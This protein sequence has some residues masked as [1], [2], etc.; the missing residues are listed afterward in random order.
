MIN[1]AVGGGTRLGVFTINSGVSNTTGAITASS[2]SQVAGSTTF[3]ALSTSGALGINLTGSSYTLIGNVITTGTGPLTIQNTGAL[4]LSG[5]VFSISGAVTQAGAGT[6]LSSAITAGAAIQFGG[7]VATS[8]SPSLNTSVASESIQLLSTLNGPGAL[9]L[10]SGGA[11]TTLQTVGQTTRLGTLTFTNA[12]NISTGSI[13]A[14]SI[15]STATGTT[16]LTGTLNT[17]AISGIEL[18]GNIFN[19]NDTI[20]TTNGGPCSIAHTGLLT[21]NAGASTLL[22]GSFTETGSANILLSGTIH[23]VNSNISF[24]NPITL[25]NPT[26]LNSDG[27]GD[28]LISNTVDGNTDLD[29][30]AG[31]GNI[32]ITANV[33][34]SVPINSMTINSANNVTTQSVSAGFI[35]QLAGGGLTLFNGSVTTT[36]PQ[37]IVLTGN[38]FTFEAPVTTQMSGPVQI[39]NA[40]LLSITSGAPMTLTGAFSQIGSGAVSLCANISSSGGNSILFTS[41]VTLCNTVVLDSDVGAGDVIFLSSVDGN[42]NLTIQAGSGNIAFSGG[43]GQ[44]TPLTA[45]DVT[46]G[47]NFTSPAISAASIDFSGLTGLA[48]FNGLLSTTGVLGIN[49]SGNAFTFNGNITTISNGP[50]TITSSGPLTF[51]PSG[52]LTISGPLSFN[53]TGSISAGGSITTNNQNIT[54]QTPLVLTGNLA[55]NPGSGAVI[56]VN[57]LDGSYNLNI[58]TTGAVTA[59]AAIGTSVPL[60]N[61]TITAQNISLD[62]V[63]T[64]SPGVSG[65][66]ALTAASA[67]N[68]DSVIY[69]AGSQTY[70]AGTDINF[71]AGATTT[72]LTSGGPIAFTSGDIVLGTSSNLNINTNGGSFSYITLTGTTFENLAINTGSG[73]AYMNPVTGTTINNITVNAGEID[74]VGTINDV[75]TN[76][77]S[78][79]AIF[80]GG[81]PQAINSTNTATFNALDGNVGTLTSPIL[82][83]TSNKIFAGAGGD[84]QSLAD[85]DGT[86]VDDTVHPIPSNPPCLIIFNDIVIK[87]C[88][89]PPVPPTPPSPPGQKR[90]I[91]P[92]PFAVPGVDSSF[93]NLAS[94][95]FFLQYFFDLT[96]LRKEVAMEY[97]PARRRVIGYDE[98]SEVP[99]ELTS[100]HDK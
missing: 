76:F 21:L 16:T 31:T 72:L 81:I 4:V 27:G 47:G 28:I 98:S 83:N 96:Y 85:F 13:N 52:I 66:L 75:N 55:I 29:L 79:G 51:S 46:S 65:A 24:A 99:L 61:L 80:N 37:G 8:G 71:I 35:T 89:V 44:I 77:T 2:I 19:L 12:R 88:Q 7:P 10:N 48:T 59:E 87:Q 69:N 97:I 18:N 45:F 93:F 50:L 38:Q 100:A 22:S 32:T 39:A 30:I 74:L 90:K 41:P 33:G 94:D 9:T 23:A 64:T 42:E 56:F 82:V 26:V 86:S 63:G 53:G 5:P 15:A 78:A 6:T 68:L 73:I 54:F 84:P 1:G 70:T 17:N 91:P 14:T 60:S 62:G 92:F 25:I 36:T 57:D 43:I 20:T 40:G 34:S 58:Q 49:L 67:I 3:G 11:D 95:Y